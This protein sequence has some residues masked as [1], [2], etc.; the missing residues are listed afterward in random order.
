MSKQNSLREAYEKIKKNN[1]SPNVNR[2]TELEQAVANY[3]KSWQGKENTA[4][5]NKK[6]HFEKMRAAAQSNN[7]LL[8]KL[9]NISE[10]ISKQSDL[11]SK[12][13][14]A[15]EYNIAVKNQGYAEKYK[16]RTYQQISDFIKSD[17]YN[18]MR[19]RGLIDESEAQWL[20]NHK[21]A[22]G[23]ST[24]LQ[25]ELDSIED[26]LKKAESIKKT[27][28]SVTVSNMGNEF[29][30]QKSIM[31]DK[32]DV[33]KANESFENQIKALGYKSV[34]Q[35]NNDIENKKT[36]ADI[37]KT[38]IAQKKQIESFNQKWGGIK[39][40]E[41]YQPKINE[42]ETDSY[43]I[44]INQITPKALKSKTIKKHSKSA[45]INDRIVT[46]S[47][48]FAE[49]EPEEKNKYN[50]IYET[51]GITTANQYADDLISL[52]LDK[53]LNEKVMQ[54]SY[55]FTSKNVFNAVVGSIARVGE[56]LGSGIEYVTN[57]L[58]GETDRRVLSATRA[59]GLREGT[60][61][62]WDSDVWD[63]VYDTTMS[64][65]DSA[66][67]MAL[68][69]AV[70]YLGEALLGGSAA[71]HTFN[72]ALDRGVP[73]GDAV[74]SSL[75]AGVAESLFE[76]VSIGTVLKGGKIT[77]GWTKKGLLQATKK[78]LVD[79]GVNFS[80]ETLT[81]ISNVITDRLINGELSNYDISV[82]DYY[83]QGMSP[84]DA[85]RKA[86]EDV[87]TQIGMAGLSGMLMGFGFGTIGST[88]GLTKS[89][90][91]NSKAGSN[92]VKNGEVEALK[93]L[94]KDSGIAEIQKAAEKIDKNSKPSKIGYVF[95]SLLEE[96]SKNSIQQLTTA[97]LENGATERGS[98]SAKGWATQILKN[99]VSPSNKEAI[100]QEIAL[101]VN[102]LTGD[103]YANFVDN[104][105]YGGDALLN[106]L[107]IG[108]DA[109][110][111][112]G[113]QSEVKT[114]NTVINDQGVEVPVAA[115]GEGAAVG[116]VMGDTVKGIAAAPRSGEKRTITEAYKQGVAENLE[117]QRP[118]PKT[119]K[120]EAET[121]GKTEE[122]IYFEEY[123]AKEKQITP[124]EE[125][126]LKDFAK[127]NGLKVEFTDKAVD[128]KAY[129]RYA[130]GTIVISRYAKKPMRALFKHEFSHS[131][132]KA[133]GYAKFQK[134]VLEESKAF[135]G[136]LNVKGFENWKALSNSIVKNY[137]E[138][139]V[140][141]EDPYIKAKADII[142]DFVGDVLFGEVIDAK[143]NPI[144][145]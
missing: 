108:E 63:F 80:E 17:D 19:R 84:E 134:Y 47:D 67:G 105:K 70:P 92:V 126:I 88:Y 62:H 56:S 137:E 131:I 95:N 144:K 119:A 43:Y 77:A 98:N 24:Q 113:T 132:E 116:P 93:T 22:L 78:T 72:N 12:Y 15:D 69:V 125:Q 73:Q 136:W 94:A 27:K 21:Y 3:E 121:K 142:A 85:K 42:N 71:A 8:K 4:A 41:N 127:E 28:G 65:I 87:G 112:I 37:L 10:S 90:M 82:R 14:T 102:K 135:K 5:L 141:Y 76:H 103:V 124:E 18:T 35:F 68:S 39:V 128:G 7:E 100:K 97:L 45:L 83:M 106:L 52:A 36:T 81:E 91:L 31:P 34:E 6:L 20:R 23:T 32:S 38:V 33:A 11:Y 130:D 51:K 109:P 57:L 114:G 46:N 66:S 110:T 129:G 145:L 99:V 96:Y 123:F 48:Y 133:K 1:T 30:P 9:N 2:L 64:G 29:N 49:M 115:D 107:E 53:R 120:A 74:L 122:E 44:A 61:S 104:G 117:K 89:Q 138:S 26:L 79:M 60:K 111:G 143:G 101:R 75:A 40:E 139:G 50:K 25:K 118:N 59:Q 86:A 54:K 140:D 58:K 16:N 55:D 13:K